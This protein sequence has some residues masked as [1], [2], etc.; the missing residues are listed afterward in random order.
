MARIVQHQGSDGAAQSACRLSGN[1]Q[2][3]AKRF[4]HQHLH[5]MNHGRGPLLD[6]YWCRK[7]VRVF[8]DVERGSGSS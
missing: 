4:Y 1:L 3:R 2:D 6:D 5:E 8:Y 7:P